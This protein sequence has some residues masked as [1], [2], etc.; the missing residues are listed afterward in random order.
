[1]SSILLHLL[2]EIIDIFITEVTWKSSR[3]NNHIQFANSK[4]TRWLDP[5]SS[6]ARLGLYAVHFIYIFNIFLR[7]MEDL[8]GH[9]SA[10]IFS[11]RPI[12]AIR[13]STRATRRMTTMRMMVTCRPLSFTISSKMLTCW[14]IGQQQC[15]IKLRSFRL[16][17]GLPRK[18]TTR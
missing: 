13:A 1:M 5:P 16:A 15:K 3:I 18:L 14:L 4:E 11:S 6:M 10:I 7:D 2:C 17:S 12:V 8:S 9:I